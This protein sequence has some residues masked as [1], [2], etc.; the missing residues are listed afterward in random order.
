M[1]RIECEEETSPTPQK[2]TGPSFTFRA[3]LGPEYR[4]APNRRKNQENDH[5]TCPLTVEAFSGFKTGREP[6]LP[7]SVES[8]PFP[9]NKPHLVR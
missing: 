4:N 7:P 3:T 6:I 1:N 5:E 9:N 8:V 2:R